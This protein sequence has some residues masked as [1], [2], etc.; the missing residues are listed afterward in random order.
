MIH[1][2]TVAEADLA[3]PDTDPVIE[4]DLVV[5]QWYKADPHVTS[6]ALQKNDLLISDD[7]NGDTSGGGMKT[8]TS[9]TSRSTR[10]KTGRT[11]GRSRQER[12]A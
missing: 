12:R 4:K 10:K 5:I 11:A 3:P 8:N 2:C 9:R 1:S 6:A 7:M